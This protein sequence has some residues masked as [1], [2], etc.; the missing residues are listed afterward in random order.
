MAC[1]LKWLFL[2]KKLLLVFGLL[3]L[4]AVV[5][6]REETLQA[7][8]EESALIQSLV[9]ILREGT[10]AMLIVGAIIAYLR[11]SKNEKFTRTVYAGAALAIVASIAT[12]VLFDSVFFFG[13]EQQE[14]LEGITLLLAATVLLFVTNWMLGKAE[15]IRW[16]KYIKE[17]A[18]QAI[19]HK[20]SLALGAVSFFAVYREGFETV[21]FFKALL[22]QTNNPDQTLFG[23]GIGLVMLSVPFYGIIKLG[24]KIPVK[25]FFLS[26]SLLLFVFAFSFAGSGVHELQEAGIASETAAG[27][28]PE[29]AILG[30]MPTLETTAVQALV[31]AFGLAMGYIHIFRHHDLSA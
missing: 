26:T 1:F 29:I 14:L 31:L 22:F 20:N 7:A 9:I 8:P 15:A 13:K 21:L 30:I 25:P 17:K 19:S 12:A 24:T 11:V 3:V 10:E 27:F 6:A 2:E 28:I 23:I 16:Q 5:F 4:S 18:G